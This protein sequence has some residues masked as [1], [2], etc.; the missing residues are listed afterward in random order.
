MLERAGQETHLV[1]AGNRL[2]PVNV[3]EIL[4][5]IESDPRE[6]ET[7][8][9]VTNI[10]IGNI[11]IG[12]GAKVGDIVLASEIQKSFN[13]AEAANIQTELKETLKQLAEAVDAMSKSLSKEQAANAAENLERL[14][15]EATKPRPNRKWYSISIEGLIQAAEHLDKLGEPV[16][17]LSQKVFSLLA[18]IL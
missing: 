15:D 14:V 16:I 3:R 11:T 13:K 17:S 4:S 10:H 7:G 8:G 5:A 6:K 12:E 18:H 9:R 2:I 1:Q